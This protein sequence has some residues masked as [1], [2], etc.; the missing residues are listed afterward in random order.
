[1]PISREPLILCSTTLILA[2][3]LFLAITALTFACSARIL[4]TVASLGCYSACSGSKTSSS[5]SL[6]SP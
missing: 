3:P 1:V 2:S 5:W 6:V 4:R